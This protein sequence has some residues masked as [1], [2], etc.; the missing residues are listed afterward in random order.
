M[1]G[2][3]RDQ[4]GTKLEHDIDRGPGADSGIMILPQSAYLGHAFPPAAK[5]TILM[6]VLTSNDK[7]PLADNKA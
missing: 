3:T 7:L 1:T 5:V 4:V 6:S 2:L